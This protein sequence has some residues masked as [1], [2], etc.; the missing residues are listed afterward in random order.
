[1]L[2]IFW[3]KK[4]TLTERYPPYLFPAQREIAEEGFNSMLLPHYNYDTVFAY[5][6]EYDNKINSGLPAAETS[7]LAIDTT[8]ETEENAE[9][10][11][12][13]LLLLFLK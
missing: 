7:F 1:M 11:G 8:I 10:I 4:Q 13:N 2:Y 9:F 5:D 6:I 3:N 12:K